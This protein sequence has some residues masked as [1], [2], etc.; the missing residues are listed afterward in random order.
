M[1]EEQT[2]QVKK[3]AKRLARKYAK[4]LEGVQAKQIPE[5]PNGI[6]AEDAGNFIR[7][8]GL[9]C[10]Y[11]Y[12]KDHLSLYEKWWSSVDPKAQRQIDIEA[13]KYDC[14]NDWDNACLKKKG[15]VARYKSDNGKRFDYDSLVNRMPKISYK[16]FVQARTSLDDA[17]SLRESHI[18]KMR[19]VLNSAFNI[20]GHGGRRAEKSERDRQWY[21][22]RLRGQSYTQIVDATNARIE[23]DKD[24]VQE[25]VVRKAVKAFEASR[26]LVNWSLRCCI[27]FSPPER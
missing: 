14:V 25:D 1:N 4:K 21:V 12:I 7:V 6:T 9:F 20:P 26:E 27:A 15:L 23:K 2:A 11:D 24:Y 17:M 3:I 16:Q 13:A 18:T 19:E 10:D 22:Q 5:I 8:N